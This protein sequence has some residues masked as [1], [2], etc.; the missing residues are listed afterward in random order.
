[1]SF[2]SLVECPRPLF[3]ISNKSSL[4]KDSGL[5]WPRRNNGNHKDPN[6]IPLVRLNS[7]LVWSVFKSSFQLLFW[8]KMANWRLNLL[9]F[10]KQPMKWQN[11]Y[12]QLTGRQWSLREKV[13]TL[14]KLK[15]ERNFFN[16]RKGVYEKPLPITILNR[17][18]QK[19]FFQ[20][21]N[22]GSSALNILVTIALQILPGQ[23]AFVPLWK[24]RN[25][26]HSNWKGRCKT[27]Y[28]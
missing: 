20:R 27:F 25:K 18:R 4:L 14:S 6:Q 28:L 12:F 7:M 15:L 9:S 26:K 19:D 16:L 5:L 10:V 22:T 17:E 11:A 8:A 1:V 2:V 21:K 3:H 13:I 23:Y 24:K